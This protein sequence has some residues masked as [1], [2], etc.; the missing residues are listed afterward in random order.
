MRAAF[1]Q[2]THGDETALPSVIVGKLG[3]TDDVP[4]YTP[5]HTARSTPWVNPIL[6]QLTNV[7]LADLKLRRVS[8]LRDFRLRIRP[9]VD[10]P[11]SLLVPPDPH[12]AEIRAAWGL[13][14]EFGFSMGTAHIVGEVQAV[15]DAYAPGPAFERT[16]NWVSARKRTST[17]TGISELV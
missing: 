12:A 10:D 15:P 11:L 2:S 13:K 16:S 17:A 14:M 5:Q 6:S 3:S 8:A 4:Q 1:R 9:S 7:A